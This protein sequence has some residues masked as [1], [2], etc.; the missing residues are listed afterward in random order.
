YFRKK[1]GKVFQINP[2][3]VFVKQ[4]K[5]IK[6]AHHN[7]MGRHWLDPRDRNT[8]GPR[9]LKI[10]EACVREGDDRTAYWYASSRELVQWVIMFC[11]RHGQAHQRN[12]PTVA[13]IIS[14][15]IFGFARH[16]MTVTKDPFI[17]AMAARYA[18]GGQR[19]FEAFSKSSRTRALN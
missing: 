14:G 15:D 3:G 5:G 8:F 19:I 16:V 18:A 11:A 4:L 12:L 10:A 17:R 6:R 1:F 13:R 9:A 7:P 2:Y